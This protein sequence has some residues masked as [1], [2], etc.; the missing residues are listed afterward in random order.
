MSDTGTRSGRSSSSKPF[1]GMGE[2]SR[3]L[4]VSET[5]LRRWTD[6]GLIRVFM[7][8]GGHRRYS[9]SE[10]QQ[11]MRARQEMQGAGT[12]AGHLQ[13]T[14]PV[15]RTTARKNIGAAFGDARFSEEGRQHLARCGRELLDLVIQ[16][17]VH[18]NKRKATVQLVRQVGEEHGRTLASLGFPLVDSV[19]AFISHRNLL[20]EAA[21]QFG[22]K[23]HLRSER[24]V[25]A[26]PLVNRLLDEALVG[27]VAAHQSC[28]RN[29]GAIENRDR[30]R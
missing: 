26:I 6:G 3:L 13:D 9:A 14:V 20:V 19:E 4:G 25:A 21:A 5:T 2:A 28:W 22:R 27:L 23:R 30:G 17:M 12:M 8:P 10:L 24:A 1:L 15:H 18:P 11:F 7:T 29:A 16:Y